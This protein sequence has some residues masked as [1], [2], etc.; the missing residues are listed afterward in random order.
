MKEGELMKSFELENLKETQKKVLIQKVKEKLKQYN[1]VPTYS[2]S[3]DIYAPFQLTDIQSSYFVGKQIENI[4]CHSYLEFSVENL[5]IDR[6]ENAWNTLIQYHPMLRAKITGNGKQVIQERVDKYQF[7]KCDWKDKANPLEELNK[8]RN[9]MSH[10]VYSYNTW[11]LFDIR[12]S[13]IKGQRHTVHVS[14]D[15]WIVDGNSAAIIYEQWYKLYHDKDYKLE[16]LSANFRDYIV[17]MENFKDSDSYKKCIEYWT[18][19]LTP[20]PY[21]ADLPVRKEKLNNK[22][23]RWTWESS[24][25]QWKKFKGLLKKYKV[26]PTSALITMFSDSISEYCKQDEFGIL[27]TYANRFQIHKDIN[28][29]IGPFTT[30]GVFK[31][32]KNAEDTL[33]SRIKKSQKQIFQ[34]LDH[35]Y[36]SGI[37]ALK[38]HDR[39]AVTSPIPIV[40][41]SMLNN[42]EL[43]DN[44]LNEVEFSVSQTPQIYLECQ[45]QERKG[46]LQ[47]IWDIAEGVLIE[48]EIQDIFNN[49]INVIQLLT[50]KEYLINERTVNQHIFEESKQQLLKLASDNIDQKIKLTHLQQSYIA[51]RLLNP[52]KN[53]A[54]VYRAFDIEGLDINKLE[55]ALNNLIDQKDYLQNYPQENG[56]IGRQYEASEYRISVKDFTNL[57]D[58]QKEKENQKLVNEMEEELMSQLNSLRF[59]VYVS[60][61]TGNSYRIHTMLDMIW[62]DGFSTWFFYDC[63]FSKYFTNETWISKKGEFLQYLIAREEYEKTNE[64]KHDQNYWNKKFSKISSGPKLEMQGKRKSNNKTKLSYTLKNTNSLLNKAMD[65]QVNPI[66]IFLA[67]FMEVICKWNE[68]SDFSL[69]LAD[70]KNR[71]HLNDKNDFGD[72]THLSWV[73]NKNDQ[74]SLI[75][76][77]LHVQNQLNL[78]LQHSWGNPLKSLFTTMKTYN[79]NLEFPIVVTNCLESS[80]SFL[81]YIDI[82]DSFSKTPNI[83]IDKVIYKSPEGLAFHWQVNEE[84]VPLHIATEI[85]QE[86]CHQL[87][88][89]LEVSN[90][91]INVTEL[92]RKEENLVY[93][94]L[95]EEQQKFVYDWNQWNQTD[96]F[97]NS[98]LLIHQLFEKKVESKPNNIAIITDSIQLSYQ[99]LNKQANQLAH[100]LIK[101]GVKKGDLVGVYLDR[102]EK[103]I[104]SLLSILKVGAAYVP[105]N[106]DDP[107]KRVQSV[108]DSSGLTY[109]ISNSSLLDLLSSLKVESVLLDIEEDS[110]C[111]Q[112]DNNPNLNI[113]SDDLAYVIFTSGS[114]GTPKGVAVKHKPVINLIEWAE[115]TF[116]FSDNDR[117]LFVNPI[118]FDLSVFDIFGLLSYGGSIYVVSDEDKYNASKLLDLLSSEEITFWNSAPAYLQLLVP[119]INLKKLKHTEHLR[120]V[121]L[122]GDWIPLTLPDNIRNTFN[123]AE[124]I[125]LGGATEATVWSNYYRIG[126]INKEWKSIPYGKPIQNARYYILNDELKPCGIGEVGNLY[127][128]GECLSEGY[129]NNEIETKN[130]FIPDFYHEK[131]SMIMYKTGDLARYFND[132]NI[133]FLGRADYQVKIRGFRIELGEIESALNSIGFKNAVAV[134]KKDNNGN[135]YIVGFG[136]HPDIKGVLKEKEILNQLNT[137]LPEYMKPSQVVSLNTMPITNNGKIDRKL[138]TNASVDDL[139]KNHIFDIHGGNDIKQI[140]DNIRQTIDTFILQEIASVL[141]KELS[142]ID[143]TTNIGDLG[144]N[145]LQYTILS[146]KVAEKYN[147][148]IN[149]ALFFKY[150]TGEEIAKFIIDNYHDELLGTNTNSELD[151]IQ[152]SSNYDRTKQVPNLN[153][154]IKDKHNAPNSLHSDNDIAIIGLHS[155]M[156]QSGD[157]KEFWENLI[158]GVDTSDEIPK[159]RWDWKEYYGNP[160]QKGNYTNVKHASFIKDIDKFD[161][162]FFGI[163]PREAELMDPRQRLL[164]EGTWKTLEDAGYKPSELRGSSIGVFIGATGD[165]Y[166]TM[167]LNSNAPIDQ[168]SLI[169]GSRTILANRISY[170]FDW[171]GP[172]EVVDTACSSSLVSIHRAIN[173][174]RNGE[175]NLAI[176]GGI[177]IMIDPTPHIS[178]NKVGMLSPD[179]KCKTF[180][181]SADG[182]GRGEGLGILLLKPLEKAIRDKDHIYGI[183]KGSA[184]NHGGKANAL[185]APNPKAQTEVILSAYRNANIDPIQIGFIETHGTGTPLGDPI[186]IEGLKEAYKL[187]SEEYGEKHSDEEHKIAL[188]AVKTNIGHLESAAGIAGLVKLILALYHKTLPPNIHQN[189]LN[190]NIDIMNSPFFVVNKLEEW[191]SPIDRFGN[192]LP[193][194]GGVSSFGFGGVN[195]H[196]LLE[197]YNNEN[198]EYSIKEDPVIIPLSAKNKKSL[199]EYVKELLIYIQSGDQPLIRDLAFTF[200]VG[201]EAFNERLVIVVKNYV[202]LQQKLTAFLNGEYNI[203]NLFY[204]NISHLKVDLKHLK[205]EKEAIDTIISQ[206]KYEEIARLWSWGITIEWDRLYKGSTPLKKPVPTYPFAKTSYWLKNINGFFKNYMP[207]MLDVDAK[208]TKLVKI[209]GTEEV[210]SNHII[211]GEKILP[212]AAYLELIRAAVEI[213][214]EACQLENIIWL[215]SISEQQLPNNFYIRMKDQYEKLSVSIQDSTG[216]DYC[217]AE[218]K[219]VKHKN[220]LLKMSIDEIQQRVEHIEEDC[221]SLFNKLGISYGEGFEVIHHFKY[222]QTEALSY[223]S[224]PKHLVNTNYNY[225]LHPS[226]IDGALQSALLLQTLNANTSETYLPF[227]IEKLIFHKSIPEDCYVYVSIQKETK[228]Y[229]KHNIFILNTDGEV[230]VEIIGCMAR[231]QRNKKESNMVASN[232]LL[233]SNIQYFKNQWTEVYFNGLNEVRTYQENHQYLL[234]GVPNLITNMMDMNGK[235]VYKIYPVK[236]HYENV[237]SNEVKMDINNAE[238]WR[239]LLERFNQISFSPTHIVYWHDVD[240]F[241]E[242]L[243][244]DYVESS[245]NPVFTMTKEIMR[246]KRS[247]QTD[248]IVMSP[249][250]KLGVVEPSV[251]AL[252]GFGKSLQKENPKINFKVVHFKN[253]QNEKGILSNNKLF[254]SLLNMEGL[255]KEENELLYDFS[256]NKLYKNSIEAIKAT[257]KG[258]PIYEGRVYIVTGGLGKIGLQITQV[259]LERNASVALIGRSRLEDQELNKVNNNKLKYYSTDLGN[260]EEL[261]KTIVQIKRELGAISGIFHCAG[262]VNDGL[263]LTKS[264]NNALDT[265]NGKVKGLLNLDQGTINENL[266]FFVLFSSLTSITGNVGQT[267]YA[268]ANRFLDYYAFLRNKQVETNVRHGRTISISW[269]LWE[270]GGMS[271]PDRELQYIKEYYGLIPLK[272]ELAIQ[273]LFKEL[274]C[275]IPHMTICLGDRHK[276]LKYLQIDLKRTNISKDLVRN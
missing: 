64:Y 210:L 109:I 142:E 13:K 232:D 67:I 248:F 123:N 271:L 124:I 114:T 174:I 134:V 120:L 164:L 239:Q 207:E 51:Q 11:P 12:I 54:I 235:N 85:F 150:N 147:I 260:R 186:E 219:N 49:F 166:A 148:E 69:V 79:K 83:G 265:L 213:N 237:S 197:E 28:K 138:L 14:M 204:E 246:F 170:L 172:S 129:I 217:V 270:N 50:D 62:F 118:S 182:Y 241:G 121:F 35:L 211:N 196:I 151:Y 76:K 194:V 66:T 97:Y 15:S 212:A 202:E 169:G 113:S 89:L 116:H 208:E 274:D 57:Q 149:P 205:N 198:T 18:N 9:E 32:Q 192:T 171:N 144:F 48:E 98:S 65:L 86:Y 272:S 257:G 70:Y 216:I 249:L 266:D 264:K 183:V 75:Q 188:G 80:T 92:E 200:Q 178:L 58:N 252:S 36:V 128:G 187:Y 177:N 262:S 131:E 8:L 184:V 223:M 16:P 163:S 250:N 104:V 218:L 37:S 91:D 88:Y 78:D 165:E 127:I 222:N 269:P 195:A 101:K 46:K 275:D 214:L 243:M 258:L 135:Q 63:L 190:P 130:C 40:F 263:L 72:Y 95:N 107:I 90:W 5:D 73:E 259:L 25:E 168:F 160:T 53:S 17:S 226:L 146:A 153:T 29:V 255:T 209:D 180:D 276:V 193:R 137:L 3:D 77:L 256:R 24:E 20:F 106:N 206:N 238:Y 43:E 220:Q 41:T 234:I 201:R 55:Q 229:K 173:A 240:I 110:I 74:N 99:E 4:G 21:S 158:N 108:I 39:E 44:W 230:V 117:V 42:G 242:N 93:V 181:E 7:L 59:V 143:L 176:A 244:L 228:N 87:D 112:F 52:S 227:S 161:A 103:V 157:I 224:I 191:R 31:V 19:K 105:L 56:K 273:F 10:K 119:F 159:E 122:S 81:K 189:K 102:S 203:S 94:N 155:I 115:K 96:A 225:L 251:G 185:T 1:R 100:Y 179:G 71:N 233:E 156:P 139:L 47:V 23:N 231:L 221:Y 254:T 162:K 167:T 27:M 30:S 141:E 126:E 68:K 26:N 236:D 34:D 199:L 45:L 38:A 84:L 125:S 60:K 261:E 111:R 215:R 22:R 61:H 253:Y 145:S 82:T 175:C 140:S 132:G 267:D 2:K 152:D 136:E 154:S 268:Y 133:E 6:L 245:F 33:L 247:K